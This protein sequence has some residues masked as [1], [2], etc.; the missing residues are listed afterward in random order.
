M[1]P[2]S[3]AQP[4]PA[5]TADTANLDALRTCAITFVVASHVGNYAGWAHEDAFRLSALGFLGVAIFFV[6][7]TLVLMMSLQRQPPGTLAL[8]F[9]V[10]RVLRVYPL[11]IATVAAVTALAFTRG[12]ADAWV[13][14]TNVLLVQNI[15]GTPSTP[16][17]LWSLPYEVQM[18]LVLPAMFLLT[19]RRGSV[20]WALAGWLACIASLALG[21]Q[22]DWGWLV[23]VTKLAPCFVPGLV[24]YL[25]ARDCPRRPQVSPAFLFAGVTVLAVVFPAAVARG[26]S[27]PAQV[28]GMSTV[29][30]WFACL[31]LGL[32]IPFT[33]PL[34]SPR[35]ALACKTVAT[36]SYGIYLI[37]APVL[38]EVFTRWQGPWA[39]KFGA[40]VAITAALAYAAHWLIEQPGIRLGQ[41]WAGALRARSAFGPTMA[42]RPRW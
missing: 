8:P 40:F 25:I 32:A 16:P 5:G 35:V 21:W 27:T 10:R 26:G 39:A 11:S 9:F 2:A 14:I 31:A 6:H 37:H 19:A 36:Y 42:A 3:S 17:P 18:Y 23:L 29:L 34:R 15:A 30:A 33:R 1:T 13:F 22:F 12:G 24:A 28:Q 38:D 4:Q 7:T 41:R 20:V